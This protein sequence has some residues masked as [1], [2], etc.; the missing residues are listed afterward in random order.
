MPTLLVCLFLL[1]ALS[2]LPWINDILIFTKAIVKAFMKPKLM[3]KHRM[4]YLGL[5]RVFIGLEIERDRANHTL[6]LHLHT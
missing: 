1:T 4:K 3:Q 5:A 6:D 2:V